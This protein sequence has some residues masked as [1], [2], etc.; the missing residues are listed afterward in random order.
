MSERHELP[1]REEP[2]PFGRSWKRLYSLVLV[3]LAV[4]IIIFYVFTKVFE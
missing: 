1:P 3:L 4:Q 2:P